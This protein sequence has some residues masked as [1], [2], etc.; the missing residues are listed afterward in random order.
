MYTSGWCITRVYHRVYL[1]VAHTRVY[2]RVY[3]SVAHTRVYHRV[4]TSHNGVY[5]RVYTSHNGVYLRVCNRSVHLSYLRVCNRCVHLS[6]LRVVYTS[7]WCKPQGEVYLR[8]NL[9]GWYT[10]GVVLLPGLYSRFTVGFI[11][12][13]LVH[14]CF[15]WRDSLSLL[16]VSLLVDVAGF[17]PLFPFHCFMVK[18]GLSGSQG[19]SYPPPWYASYPPRDPSNPLC[20]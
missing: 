3:L 17:T 12:C 7:G 6:Y 11:F 19:P 2:Y 5:H 18:R 20:R 9:R 14:H 1:S 16:P 15:L 8:V 13:L 10:L 4:Y